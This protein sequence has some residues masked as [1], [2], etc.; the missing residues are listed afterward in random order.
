MKRYIIV[1]FVIAVGLYTYNTVWFQSSFLYN[2]F[3]KPIANAP[4]DVS[5]KGNKI[6]IPLEQKNDTC[7]V[8]AISVPDRSLFF[9]KQMW[10]GKL[11][12]RFVAGDKV[13]Y[14]GTARP[15]FEYR[16]YYKG[17]TLIYLAVFD[18]PAQDVE[19]SVLEVE[20]LEPLD[21][22]D[23]FVGTVEGIVRANYSA[24]LDKCSAEDLRIY[25]A[26]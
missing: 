16:N 22:L 23:G 2:D 17:H 18:L 14:G 25:L 10:N 26:N 15:D 24:K 21:F 4:F 12:L 6:A 1:A 19:R 8:F 11:R 5:R 13:L 3:Y 7:Y 20:V 9:T